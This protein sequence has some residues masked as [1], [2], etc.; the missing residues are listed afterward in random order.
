VVSSGVNFTF[1]LPLALKKQGRGVYHPPQ[2]RVEVKERVELYLYFPFC[3]F[4]DCSRVPLLI[5]TFL[6][7]EVLR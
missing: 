3:A 5:S 6:K 4:L 2:P 1:T 7:F